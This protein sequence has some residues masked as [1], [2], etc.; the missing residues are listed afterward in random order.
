MSGYETEQEQIEAIKRWWKENGTAVIAG[1]AIGAASLF[2]WSMWADHTRNQQESASIAYQQ[3]MD[4]LL[5]GKSDIVIERAERLQQEH[6]DSSYAILAAMAAAKAYVDKSDFGAA[7]ERLQWVVDNSDDTGIKHIARLRLARL[8]VAADE[9]EEALQL[10]DEI[11]DPAGFAAEY[12]EL[13]GDIYVATDKIGLA[14][15]AY[16]RALEAGEVSV[17]GQLLQ[18]KLDDLGPGDRS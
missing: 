7:Q 13:K 1:L 14:R 2:G 4:S 6:A 10:L 9:N 15:T 3:L 16:K 5:D 11:S 8:L 12:H 18:M 17:G